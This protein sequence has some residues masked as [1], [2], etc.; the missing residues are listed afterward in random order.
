MSLL[1]ELQD[2]VKMNNPLYKDLKSHAIDAAFNGRTH[3]TVMYNLTQEDFIILDLFLKDLDRVVNY[4]EMEGLIAYYT[5]YV[6]DKVVPDIYT[7]ERVEV[8]LSWEIGEK[9]NPL[10]TC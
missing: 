7:S 10:A 3:V 9:N 2:M 4:F 1:N 6:E 5:F 8:T